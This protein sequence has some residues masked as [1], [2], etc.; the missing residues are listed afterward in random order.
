MVRQNWKHYLTHLVCRS[1]L[2]FGF[3]GKW[4][5]GKPREIPFF[6]ISESENRAEKSCSY[7]ELWLFEKGLETFSESFECLHKK[8]RRQQNYGNLGTNWYIFS[9]ALMVHCHCL[10]KFHVCSISLHINCHQTYIDP[11]KPRPN[12]KVKRSKI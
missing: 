8:C 7:Q 6:I 9:R 5:P 2:A 12:T 11:K 3:Q 4:K 1:T 10:N